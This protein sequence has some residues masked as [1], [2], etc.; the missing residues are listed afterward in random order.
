LID[1]L[2]TKSSSPRPLLATYID[3][4]LINIYFNQLRDT[5][6]TKCEHILNKCIGFNYLAWVIFTVVMSLTCEPY[7]VKFLTVS[8]LYWHGVTCAFLCAKIL[9]YNRAHQQSKFTSKKLFLLVKSNDY[10][11]VLIP[12]RLYGLFRIFGWFDLI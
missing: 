1:T 6:T 9:I 7:N 4:L 2:F 10:Y 8:Q 3:V 12:F 5:T 11:F